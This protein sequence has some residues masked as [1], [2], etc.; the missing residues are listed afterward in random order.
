VAKA[1]TP[2]VKPAPA[3]KPVPAPK[4]A[5]AASGAW[6][7]QLGAFSKRASA[8]ALFR[9]LS[10]NGALAGRQAFYI[11]A[12]AVTR[13][14]VGPFESRAA[15]SAACNALKGQACFAVK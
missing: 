7:I 4:P 11:P 12:G 2:P 3:A 10:A 14:Q 1:E 5:V 6:R 9:K 15:A 8:E 13:L